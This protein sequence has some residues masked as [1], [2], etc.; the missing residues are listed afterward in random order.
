MK[1]LQSG[2]AL[3]MIFLFINILFII[4]LST[5]RATIATSLFVTEKM[6]SVGQAHCAMGILEW[7]IVLVKQQYETIAEK[8]ASHDFIISYGNQRARITL[9]PTI[10]AI[11][12]EVAVF[13]NDQQVSAYTC[14]MKKNK[15]LFEISGFQRKD[16]PLY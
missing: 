15:N 6:A 9:T 11:L 10:S 1:K 13:E 3:I 14:H 12:I 7:A 5:Y 4:A 8:K 16:F 2:S